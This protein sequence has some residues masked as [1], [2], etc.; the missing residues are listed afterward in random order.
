MESVVT[1]LSVSAYTFTDIPVT[2][3]LHHLSMPLH[4]QLQINFFTDLQL[5]V[6]IILVSF[7]TADDVWSVEHILNIF[8]IWGKS[9]Y[10]LFVLNCTLISFTESIYF[11]KIYLLIKIWH[12]F[13]ADYCS[14]RFIKLH[15][16]IYIFEQK[17][18]KSI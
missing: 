18:V 9:L 12:T 4:L 14:V 10:K 11:S 8:W 5:K 13:C 3:D 2:L 7:T 1:N 16:K 6:G 17:F 15:C